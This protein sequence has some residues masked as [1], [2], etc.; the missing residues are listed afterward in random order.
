MNR[1]AKA[2]TARDPLISAN[3]VRFLLMAGTKASTFLA[4]FRQCGDG[5]VMTL[6][7]SRPHS[8]VARQVTI[9][10]GAGR[11]VSDAARGRIKLTYRTHRYEYDENV[12]RAGSGGY[13]I[14]T[15]LTI[16]N[17]AIPDTL[18][19]ALPGRPLSDVI[20]YNSKPAFFASKF[21]TIIDAEKSVYPGS[22]VLDLILGIKWH[23]LS[24]VL[25]HL[26]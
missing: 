19:T 26:G 18:L 9:H 16:G 3:A 17:Q 23:R 7:Q 8:L 1:A 24:R 4:G 13:S 15:Q 22:D 21:T 14:V 25:P 6:W 20:G 10:H 5:E 2:L 11:F 12:I